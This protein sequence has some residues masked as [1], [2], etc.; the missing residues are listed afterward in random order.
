M[1]IA[2]S[3]AVVKAGLDMKHGESLRSTFVLILWV[4]LLTPST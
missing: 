2:L 3:Y 1:Y 4:I